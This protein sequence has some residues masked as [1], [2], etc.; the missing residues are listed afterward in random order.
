MQ[1]AEMLLSFLFSSTY[2]AISSLAPL[3][4]FQKGTNNSQFGLAALTTN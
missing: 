4:L 1:S 2:G 3:T